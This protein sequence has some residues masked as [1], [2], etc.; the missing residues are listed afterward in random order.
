MH[1]GSRPGSA[2]NGTSH[3]NGALL[4]MSRQSKSGISTIS[5]SF[6]DGALATNGSGLMGNNMFGGILGTVV[7]L[8]AQTAGCDFL[9]LDPVQREIQVREQYWGEILERT[10]SSQN[11]QANMKNRNRGMMPENVSTMCN[12]EKKFSSSP[13]IASSSKAEDLPLIPTVLCSAEKDWEEL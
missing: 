10:V 5:H 11:I 13:F 1:F 2:V 9:P 4:S 6:Q 3:N 8:T 7:S 12:I